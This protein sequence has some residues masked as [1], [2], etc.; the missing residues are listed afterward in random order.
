[1]PEV[2]KLVEIRLGKQLIILVQQRAQ[3]KQVSQTESVRAYH[4]K[5]CFQ[6]LRCSPLNLRNQPNVAHLD[7]RSCAHAI[8]EEPGRFWRE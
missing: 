3:S 5:K 6:K 4:W 8:E 1:M 2:V 7:Q